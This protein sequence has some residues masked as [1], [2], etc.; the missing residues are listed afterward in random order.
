[1]EDEKRLNNLVNVLKGVMGIGRLINIT[2]G[3][4]LMR[5]H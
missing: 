1:M 2:F 5:V 3:A 4:T